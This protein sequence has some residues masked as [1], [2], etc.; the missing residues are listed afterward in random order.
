MTPAELQA[1]KSQPAKV[2]CNGCTACCLRDTIHLT[3]AEAERFP[4]HL[5]AGCKVL[6]RQP[7]GACALLG[8]RGCTVHENPPDLC[9]RFDC[10]VLFLSTPKDL[11][12]VRVTQ[13]PTMRAVYEAGK[14]RLA[15]LE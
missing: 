12:R 3:D 8:T 10:R 15:T 2:P 14:R 1:R 13:N 6:D 9:R 4:W 7:G 11:R 5:E